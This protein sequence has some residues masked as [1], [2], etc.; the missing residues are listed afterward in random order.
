MKRTGGSESGVLRI[1]FLEAEEDGRVEAITWE[2]LFEK[3]DSS[4]LAFFYQ[5]RKA[6][7]SPSCFCKFVSNEP[8]SGAAQRGAGNAVLPGRAA[9]NLADQER[10]D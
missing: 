8:G 9:A 7:G 4:R 3:F 10:G 2:E 5:D 6:D 1:D